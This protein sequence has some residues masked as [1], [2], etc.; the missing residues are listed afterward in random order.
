MS[1]LT[2]CFKITITLNNIQLVILMKTEARIYFFFI[3]SS[4][5]FEPRNSGS[6]FFWQYT[7]Y[8]FPC[9][10]LLSERVPFPNYS[11]FFVWL[12]VCL[13]LT[14]KR[15]TRPTHLTKICLKVSVHGK[16]SRQVLNLPF[17][18]VLSWRFSKDAALFFMKHSQ[19]D[20]RWGSW[21]MNPHEC[22]T[23]QIGLSSV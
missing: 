23:I 4:R 17:I 22:V 11:G 16:W 12:T 10:N 3:F 5:I 21:S 2:A 7:F 1:Q 18:K 19:R 15:L 13:K 14:N 20:K 6:N 9:N 8:N